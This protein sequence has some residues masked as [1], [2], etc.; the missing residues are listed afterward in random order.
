[1][2]SGAGSLTSM[3]N[4]VS[5]IAKTPSQNASSRALAPDSAMAS[6]LLNELIS[7]Y[8]KSILA[9]FRASSASLDAGGRALV[10]APACR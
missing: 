1:M 7:I 5:A 3:I 2:L 9:P 6:C 10:R 4:S 8:T